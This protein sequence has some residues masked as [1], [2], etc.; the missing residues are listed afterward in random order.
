MMDAD[1]LKSFLVINQFVMRQ[2]HKH[3]S[4]ANASTPLLGDP[5]IL[6]EARIQLAALP[7]MIEVNLSH[8][9]LHVTYVDSPLHSRSNKQSTGCVRNRIWNTSTKQ[10]CDTILGRIQPYFEYSRQ[11][12]LISS[13]RAEGN[14]PRRI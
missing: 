1:L 8:K 14:E 3:R 7:N 11:F 6:E 2:K 10:I 4:E 5:S 12:L 13:H 9:P